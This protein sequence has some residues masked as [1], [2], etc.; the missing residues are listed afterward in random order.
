MEILNKITG[1]IKL[2]K[3]LLFQSF[4]F[5][6]KG[7]ELDNR[8]CKLENTCKGYHLKIISL[9]KDLDL[10]SKSLLNVSKKNILLETQNKNL[11]KKINELHDIS[12]FT[13]SPKNKFDPITDSYILKDSKPNFDNR[14]IIT[15]SLLIGTLSFGF[16]RAKLYN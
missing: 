5:W 13:I 8:I 2:E 14:K 1:F 4:F 9:K 11:E 3:I 16:L 6:K 12:Q 15:I 10:F 7:V